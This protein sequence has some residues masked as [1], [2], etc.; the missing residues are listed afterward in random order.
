MSVPHPSIPLF[1]SKPLSMRAPLVSRWFR[2]ID[3]EI[4]KKRIGAQ[5]E[6][7]DSFRC[8]IYFTERSSNQGFLALF[9]FRR[10][11]NSET[12]LSEKRGFRHYIDSE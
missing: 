6:H 3:V 10:K 8:S 7:R 12:I 5:A 2:S 9:Q 1:C 4:M 11:I